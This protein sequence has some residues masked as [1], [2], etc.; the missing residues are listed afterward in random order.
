MCNWKPVPGLP[1]YEASDS[2]SIR[3]IERKVKANFGIKT[4]K[5][6]ILKSAIS[7]N[8]YCR[9]SLYKDHVTS[10]Y[11]VHRII[12]LTFIP[13]PDNKPFINHINGVKT[14]NRIE[15]LEW[16]TPSENSK[17]NYVIGLQKP[18]KSALGK[19]GYDNVSSKEVFQYKNGVLINTFGS[20][21]EAQRKTGISQGQI[22]RVCRGERSH[23]RGFVFSYH[24]LDNIETV[25]EHK[26][27]FRKH[28]KLQTV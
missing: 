5:S 24:Q 2:G 9:V 13:N 26:A 25:Q 23:T 28:P 11:S 10:N 20:A 16:C 7:K 27:E 14:D 22:S 21:L 15:N 8:G 6:K 19:M 1:L 17:H 18:V 3:S 4:A 12:A